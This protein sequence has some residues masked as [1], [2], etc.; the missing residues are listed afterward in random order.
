M[1]KV[2]GRHAAWSSGLNKVGQGWTS[3]SSGL[4]KRKMEE[5]H[6]VEQSPES[7]LDNRKVGRHALGLVRYL[8]RTKADTNTNANRDI[9]TYTDP[10]WA[11]EKATL[12]TG[13]AQII[14]CDAFAGSGLEK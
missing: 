14:K 7:R 13:Q 1:E 9:N 11:I 3:W 4:D 12:Q 2:E 8:C 5:M 6:L 10:G